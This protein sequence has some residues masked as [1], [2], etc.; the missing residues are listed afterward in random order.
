MVDGSCLLNVGTAVGEFDRR[1]G[2]DNYFG[3][4][5]ARKQRPIVVVLRDD[6]ACAP[7][8]SLPDRPTTG[9]CYDSSGDLTEEP[10]ESEPTTETPRCASRAAD[11]APN[12]GQVGYAG[13]PGGQPV[14]SKREMVADLK[15]CAGMQSAG[16]LRYA[17]NCQIQRRTYTPPG[18]DFQKR[19]HVG[20][21]M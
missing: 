2:F 7:R 10:S 11:R 18:Q 5:P 12:E 15:W 14:R 16:S 17:K 19:L 4:R 1:V 21:S 6:Q 13:H 8:Y 20:A 3:R 9:A